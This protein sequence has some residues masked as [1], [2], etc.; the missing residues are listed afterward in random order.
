MSTRSKLVVVGASLAGIRAVEGARKAGFDGSIS[1]VGAEQHLPYD[2]P[3]LSKAFLEGP[4]DPPYFRSESEIADELDVRL[5][6]GAPAEK[7]NASERTILIGGE[8]ISYDGLV[9]AT[10]ATARS[11]PNAK[12]LQGVHTLRTL[13]DAIAVREALDAGAR[14]VVVGAGF[15]GSEVAS[16]ARKRDLPVTIVE[17]N[18]TP[19][20]RSVGEVMGDACSALHLANGTD[21]R[22]G[23]SVESVEGNSRVERVRLTDGTVLEADLV[24][25]GVGAEPATQWLEG[26]GLELDNGIVCDENLATTVPGVYAAGDVARWYNPIFGRHMRLEHWSSAAGQGAAAGAAAAMPECAQPFETIP[27]F[28]SDWYD[29]RIQFVGVPDCDEVEIVLGERDSG[30]FVALYR[31]EDRVAGVLAL[32]KQREIMK[33]RALIARRA[34]WSDA[35]SF[36]RTRQQ[37]ATKGTA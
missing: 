31:S 13:D 20:V 36:A 27:Y 15:I 7:L 32:N 35:L 24:V 2:R 12:D 21:L 37:L 6:L 29:S 18:P 10:G 22:C 19:L 30:S 25:V 17:A 28:W 8:E 11:L 5:V 23:V 1:L 34:S 33:F 16:G 3:P 4:C 14:T 9:I 26:S